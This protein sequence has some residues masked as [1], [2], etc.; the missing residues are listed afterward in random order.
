[1]NPTAQERRAA[2]RAAYDALLDAYNRLPSNTRSLLNA[3]F[4]AERARN[5]VMTWQIYLA[6]ILPRLPAEAL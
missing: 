1:M 4:K 2:N 6:A 3:E 5:P